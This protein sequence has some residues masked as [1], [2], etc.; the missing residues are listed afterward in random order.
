MTKK[1]IAASAALAACAAT[2]A[3]PGPRG[4][5]YV[6][7]DMSNP[8]AILA[9]LQNAFSEF[10]EEQTQAIADLRS[11]Q[12]DVVRTEK[13]ERINGQITEL[14]QALETA[15]QAIAGLQIGGGG[16]GQVD[17]AVAEH[18]QAFN[19]WF[20]RGDAAAEA[21]LPQLQINAALS[22]DSNPDGGWLVPEE[23]ANEVDRVVG[24]ISAMRDIAMTMTIGTDTYKKLVG[25]GGT[26]SGWVGEKAARTETNTPTLEELIF[27]MMEVYANPAVT[28]RS[29][30]DSRLDIAAWLANEVAI[31]FAEQEGAAFITGDGVN[32]PRGI[33]SYD[34]VANASYAWGKTGFIVSG[35]ADGFLAPT[36]SVSP[37]DCLVDLYYGLKQQYRNGA[38]WVMSDATMATVRKFKDA[39]G[40]FIWAPPGETGELSTVLGKPVVTDDNMEAVAAN[41]FPVAFG[42]FLRGYLILDR[43][44]IRVLRDPLTNKP[45]VN[46]YTTKRVAGGIQNFEAIKLLKIST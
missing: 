46:F 9:E 42:N 21:S 29:L 32:K 7:A 23:M 3:I 22:T 36:A 30:D 10:R 37:A 8:A 6:R 18:A 17:P 19:S 40:K 2:T 11:G 41:N 20:R 28:Q 38:T 26:G 16:G 1:L 12:E 14:T 44:G 45:Y 27:N 35:K 13:V 39:D 31:E 15:N 34:K 5:Q 24:T 33:L 25:V 43:F 4:I